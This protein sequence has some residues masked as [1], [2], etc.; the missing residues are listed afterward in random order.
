MTDR[1]NKPDTSRSTEQEPIVYVLDDDAHVREGLKALLKL[2]GLHSR[3]L[4][5]TESFLREHIDTVSCLVLDLRMP[6]V[7]GL[8]FQ[9]ELS[10]AGVKIPIVFISGHSDIPTTVQAMKAGR[11]RVPYKAV[12]RAGSPRCG[13]RGSGEG[14]QE[15]N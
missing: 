2:I 13:S 5:S 3:I 1:R 7:S 10:R 9:N 6:G 12:S 8:E 11:G 15:T 4:G 14:S